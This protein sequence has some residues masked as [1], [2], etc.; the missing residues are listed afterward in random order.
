[1]KWLMLTLVVWWCRSPVLDLLLN[2]GSD[3]EKSEPLSCETRKCN[4]K[5]F[6]KPSSM[7]EKIIDRELC[8]YK[9]L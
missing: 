6:L 5:H 9:T 7:L 8:C 1:M 2:N 4:Y 3:E